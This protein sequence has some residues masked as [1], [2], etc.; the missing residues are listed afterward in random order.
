MLRS[1]TLILVLIIAIVILL[2][3]LTLNKRL[4]LLQNVK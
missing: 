1:I 3:H 4:L 2:R